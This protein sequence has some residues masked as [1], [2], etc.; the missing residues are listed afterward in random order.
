MWVHMSDVSTHTLGTKEEV[1][2]QYGGP[3]WCHENTELGGVHCEQ[4]GQSLEGWF[5]LWQVWEKTEKFVM[6][7]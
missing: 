6:L 7:L 5:H 3:E 1:Y 2:L 4:G